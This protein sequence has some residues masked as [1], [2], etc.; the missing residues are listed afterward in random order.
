MN[1]FLRY[2]AAALVFV[3]GLTALSFLQEKFDEGDLRKGLSVIQEKVPEAKD[4]R[5]RMESRWRGIVDV[6]CLDGRWEVDVLRG[7]YKKRMT[8]ND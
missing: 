8:E 2:A 5:A 4:C 3:A 6:D 1:G 7:F